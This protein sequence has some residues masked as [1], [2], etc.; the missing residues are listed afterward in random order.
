M[1]SFC[2]AARLDHRVRTNVDDWRDSPRR[3]RMI[4]VSRLVSARVSDPTDAPPE[5]SVA[6]FEVYYGQWLTIGYERNP[7]TPQVAYCFNQAA[8]DRLRAQV[9]H[10]IAH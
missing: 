10:D 3:K 1:Q 5:L 7:L 9:V 8:D 2:I 4:S 6:R